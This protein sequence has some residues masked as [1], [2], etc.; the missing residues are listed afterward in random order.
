ML[1]T[2]NRQTTPIGQNKPNDMKNQ[3]VVL[4]LSV[5]AGCALLAGCSK[6][7]DAEGQ[8][9]N[10]TS[11]GAASAESGSSAMM[12]INW[13]LG[14]KYLMRM[15]VD[16]IVETHVPNQPQPVKQQVNLTQR[17]NLSALKALD[18]D[19]R[20]LELEFKDQKINVKQG[21]LTVMSF[22]SR[23]NASTEGNPV[24]PLLTK[25]IGARI[26]YQTDAGGKV[27]KVE[28]VEEL[29]TRIGF[30]RKSQQHAAFKD[31]V[32]EET[33]KRYGS[34]GEMM[35]NR[36]VKVGEDW[37]IKEQ[38]PST[39][40]T[41]DIQM[42]Y[43]FKKWEQ[44]DD[45]RCALIKADGVITP[46]PGPGGGSPVK[47]QKGTI[48]GDIW[49]DPELGMVVGQNLDQNMT[50]DINAGGQKM[51]SDLKQQIRMAMEDVVPPR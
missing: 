3:N 43:T 1:Q 4:L 51:T 17:F 34:L 21:E 20:Q 8:S 35:P 40:G 46:A 49:F 33:L 32:S 13:P 44:R 15:E 27:E 7:K 19:G 9:N 39:I 5:I 29:M 18:N 48:S 30:N 16:Q 47:V 28:G 36:V 12:K 25:M 22:D 38:V 6:A 42:N 10:S 41:L 11:S 2:S 23:D 31:F 45:R 37:S 24:A 26:Q 50:L 14:Q